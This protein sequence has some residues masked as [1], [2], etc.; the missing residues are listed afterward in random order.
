MNR[1]VVVGLT[2][3]MGSGKSTAVNMIKNMVIPVFESD[4]TVH[5]LMRD[6][7]EMKSIFQRKFPESIVNHA[8]DRAVLSSLLNSK[9]VDIQ[10]L[11]RIIYPFMEQELQAFFVRH[12]FERIV[13]LDVPLLFEAGWNRFC[14]KI[15]VMT[16]PAEVLKARVFQRTGMTEEKYEILT[17]RQMD[18]REKR[19]KADFVI[20]TQNGIDSVK[21]RLYE[22]MEE[23]IC[24]KLS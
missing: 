15:I 10:E 8:V 14:D 16:A 7:L 22:I 20:E 12:R 6:N 4:K 5:R 21:E 3:C 13:V 11:E 24:E 23:L 17:Q 9:K 1:S 19:L 2:G 18:D